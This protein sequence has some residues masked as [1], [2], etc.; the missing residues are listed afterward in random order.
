[1]NK[2]NE[3]LY[4]DKRTPRESPAVY[5]YA[6]AER[7]AKMITEKNKDIKAVYL[8]KQDTRGSFSITFEHDRGTTTGHKYYK[9]YREVFAYIEGYIIDK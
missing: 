9:T 5:Y 3:K 1:M 4:M 8:G 7:F 2:I 6:I